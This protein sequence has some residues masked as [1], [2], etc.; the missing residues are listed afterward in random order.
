M[1]PRNL[2]PC[3]RINSH[4]TAPHRWADGARSQNTMKISLNWLR[5]Y[6]DWNGDVSTLAETLTFAGV[7]VEDIK[8]RGANFDKVVVGQ[9][10]KSEQHP[11]A[12][13]LSVCQV[14]DGSDTP[15]QIVCGAKN[16]KVGDK[17]PVALPGAILPGDFKIKSG[18]LRDVKSDGMMCSAKELELADDADGLLILPPETPVGIPISQALP[19]DTII[20]IEV[21]PNRPDLLSHVGLAREVATLA[22]LTFKKPEIAS[23]PQ[24]ATVPVTLNSAKCPY[25]TVTRIEGVTVAP[26]PEWLCQKLEAVGLRPI[27][28]IVDI[29]NFVML[30]LGQP[31]H[32]FDAELL[33]G[34][35]VVRDA[36]QDE[37]F[38]ALDG[39][40]YK[41]GPADLVIAD[42]EKAVA[43]AG[44]MGGEHSGVTDST[45]TILLES[46]FFV[47]QAVRRTSRMLGL[48]SDS[49]YRFERR[50]DPAG[51]VPASARAAALIQELA[52][53]KI[54]AF[55]SA[56]TVDTAPRKVQLRYSR[57]DAIIGVAVPPARV[58]EILTG[59]GLV[60]TGGDVNEST[61][62]APSFRSDLEREIDLIEEICRVHGMD[63]IASRQLG[64]FAPSSEADRRYD[65]EMRLR[66]LLAGAGFSEIKTVTLV[67]T[68][69]LENDFFSTRGEL[70][71]VKNPLHEEQ[72]VLRP[73]L[74]SGLIDALARNIRHGAKDVRLFEIGTV[75]GGETEE[76]RKLGLLW[77][78]NASE[79][80]WRSAEIPGDF[81]HLKGV[82]ETLA[83]QKVA[84]AAVEDK[85]LAPAF[86]LQLHGKTIGRIGQVSP[87]RARDFD[88]RS[89]LVL[90]ELDV[91]ALLG[92]RGGGTRI[93]PLPKFPA[94]TRDAA[95]LAPLQLGNA[96]IEA[97][98]KGAKEP[99][100]AEVRLFD[101]FTDPSGVRV[102]ADRKSMAFSFTYRSPDRTLTTEEVNK[103]HDNLKKSMS[104]KLPIQFRE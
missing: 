73:S 8:A 92:I 96:E 27:N 99:L 46:A 13:R 83:G 48:M 68:A 26:S 65:G 21:T 33:K 69:S 24:G 102:A 93:K 34:D 81:F 82:V 42:S 31:L 2:R 55:G 89:A 18:K 91:N 45:K 38:L 90:A 56:G 64:R 41:L 39:K 94:V 86:D 32:A 62:D 20:E 77:T 71:K 88:V 36:A 97:A 78:G 16:Y 54:T 75:F 43:I 40:E 22:G 84:L 58:D 17:V 61:W 14:N 7:E 72:S 28:N 11:N 100:L 25:Y 4:W 104:A 30:E 95:I 44:V 6:A 35:I 19:S 101:L 79:A 70:V 60:K 23:K 74:S 98:I 53:G 59:F 66:Q 5:D 1:E 10:V 57:C 29:T 47:P 76:T 80:T 51:V 12:D 87:G 52:G 85:R 9:I 63:R 3:P 67:S 103:A 50:V 49:S 37:A 15:R